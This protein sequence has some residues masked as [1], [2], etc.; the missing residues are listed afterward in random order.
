MTKT[1]RLPSLPQLF[2]RVPMALIRCIYFPS[3]KRLGCRCVCIYYGCNRIIS[4]YIAYSLRE[5]CYDPLTVYRQGGPDSKVHGAN[6]GPTWVLSAPDGPHVGPMNL[7]VR[8]PFQ[9]PP[10]PRYP[11]AHWKCR[12]FPLKSWYCYCEYVLYSISHEEDYSTS[13]QTYAATREADQTVLIFI[14]FQLFFKR[15]NMNCSFVSNTCLIS[16]HVW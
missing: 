6:M 5:I 15:A 9:R 14:Q 4:R 8:G 13:R 3:Q 11:P 1:R 12:I 2:I 7:A 10:L 16:L